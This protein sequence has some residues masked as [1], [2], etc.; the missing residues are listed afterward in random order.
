M[1]SNHSDV[2]LLTYK[3]HRKDAIFCPDLV[4]KPSD[5]R[6][7]SRG[8]NT[9]LLAA[10]LQ[11]LRY[12]WAYEYYVFLDSDVAV[13]G[14]WQSALPGWEHFLQE[15]QPAIGAPLYWNENI[16]VFYTHIFNREQ[17]V[18][19]DSVRSI[20]WHDQMFTALHHEAAQ[21]VLPLDSS[22]DMLDAMI[23]QWKMQIR[24]NLLF[25]GHILLYMGMEVRNPK[26]E[27]DNDAAIQATTENISIELRE[28][29]PPRLRHCVL[30]IWSIFALQL[31]DTGFR[32]RHMRGTMTESMRL[33]PPKAHASLELAHGES[34]A[35]WLHSYY[36]WARAARKQWDYSTA[37]LET[38]SSCD[39]EPRFRGY[40]WGK[41]C[42]GPKYRPLRFA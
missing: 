35:V 23:S 36:P 3:T 38:S 28:Q 10:Q 32:A 31:S 1:W 33:K 14:T 42:H 30:D 20:Y 18:D 22:V 17:D 13:V 12:G 11:E 8:R 29:V 7:F 26:H 9:L 21:L 2:F 5:K 15:W 19:T 6:A 40:W 25:R 39:D 24:A 27:R 37:T 16:P 41:P 34:G 4:M